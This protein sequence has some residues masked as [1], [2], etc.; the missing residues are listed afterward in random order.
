MKE[1]NDNDLMFVNGG[2]KIGEFLG[3]IGSSL[4]DGITMTIKSYNSMVKAAYS[5]GKELGSYVRNL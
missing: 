5:S 4:A 2:G 1:I 3:D